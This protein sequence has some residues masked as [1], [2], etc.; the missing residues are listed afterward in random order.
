MKTLILLLCLLTCTASHAQ[1][2]S[3]YNVTAKKIKKQLE[4]QLRKLD[5]DDNEFCDLILE[6]KLS[7][8][9]VSIKKVSGTGSSLLC[10]ASKK[11]LS[12]KKK[13]RYSEV[14]KYLH[15]HVAAK[16]L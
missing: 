10:R 15:I 2:D 7:G 5:F 11:T 12:R 1:D 3:D 16:S 9:Y 8:N 4:K 13:Y 6:M 14:Q